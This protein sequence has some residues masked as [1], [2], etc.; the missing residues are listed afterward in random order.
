MVSYRYY[1]VIYL[2]RLGIYDILYYLELYLTQLGIYGVIYYLD[3]YL[4]RFANFVSHTTLRHTY[5][6]L[7]SSVSY[8]T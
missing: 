1:Q 8:T 7:V 3:I 2:P 6:D 4:P 5:P